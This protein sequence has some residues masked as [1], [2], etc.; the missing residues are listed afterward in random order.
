MI[1]AA[2][3]RE[4]LNR[5]QIP[6]DPDMPIGIMIETPS[7]ALYAGTLAQTAAFFS[8]GTNDLMQYTMAADRE[9]AA[10]AYLTESLP[11]SLKRLIA[12]TGEAAAEAGIPVSVCGELAGEEAA[13]PFLLEAG[14]TKLS[15]SPGHVLRVRAAVQKYLDEKKDQ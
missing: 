5:E 9:N 12:M 15:V 1:I 3:V 14:V 8:I 6:H 7:A 2:G 10:L 4:A 13:I 11:E